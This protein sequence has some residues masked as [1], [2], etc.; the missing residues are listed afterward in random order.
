MNLLSEHV[1]I[2][3]AEEAREVQNGHYRNQGEFEQKGYL[4]DPEEEEKLFRE[5]YLEFLEMRD[6]DEIQLFFVPGYTCNFNCSYCYQNAYGYLPNNLTREVIDA[7]FSYISSQFGTRKKYVTLF[8]GEPLLPGKKHKEGIAYF[9]ACAARTGLDVALVTNGYHLA[10]YLNEL[11]PFRIREIQVTLDGT[12]PVHDNRRRLKNGSGT[13]ARI[14]QGIDLALE[15]GYSVNLRV[16]I[17]KDNIGNLPDLARF[18]IEKGWTSNR[19]FKTQLGRNY[20]LHTCQAGSEKLFSR[21][22]MYEEITRQIR[23]HP[24]I[25][26]FHKPAYSVSK[27][28]FEEGR[29][30]QPLFDSCPGTKTEWAFDCYGKIYSCTATVGKP[31]EELGRYFPDTALDTEKI[32]LWED[33]D[34]LS[35]AACNNCTVQLGC[36]GGCAAVALNKTGSLHAP[37]CR[38]VKELAEMGIGLYFNDVIHA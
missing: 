25:M 10:D 18:A 33:R 26:E 35:I 1:D 32:S 8:G 22:S 5:K 15:Q 4:V 27:F 16:V 19:L 20:E 17:D 13:F 24:Y 9:L 3:T 2:L 30:P 37:D 11:K 7:F 12:Q 34:I 38:P 21:I 6:N 14:V 31:G 28:L 23:K 36:G 29:L